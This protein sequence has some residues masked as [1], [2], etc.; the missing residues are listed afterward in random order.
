MDPN[1]KFVLDRW[2]SWSW[3]CHEFNFRPRHRVKRIVSLNDI[4]TY[5]LVRV[6]WYTHCLIWLSYYSRKVHKSTLYSYPTN[7]W[8]HHIHIMTLLIHIMQNW[9]NFSQKELHQYQVTLSIQRKK[10]VW[11]IWWLAF[12]IH[13]T[14][15]TVRENLVS[16]CNTTST[17]IE[18]ALWYLNHIPAHRWTFTSPSIG[19]LGL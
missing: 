2:S 13:V 19:V 3:W 12:T 9:E 7:I 16:A 4:F 5:I 1:N 14:E 18:C 8:L 11:E 10:S 6:C 17:P 15:S